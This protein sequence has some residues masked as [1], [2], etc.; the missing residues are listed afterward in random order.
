MHRYIQ[1]FTSYLK[2][3]SNEIIIGLRHCWNDHAW[4]RSR[5]DIA[6]TK[7]STV[8]LNIFWSADLKDFMSY[9]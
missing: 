2:E 4:I 1:L 3:L 6:D 8:D 9:I 5:F 7:Y